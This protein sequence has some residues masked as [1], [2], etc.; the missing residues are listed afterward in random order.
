MTKIPN[1]LQQ[2]LTQ[3]EQLD[4]QK[5]WEQALHNLDPGKRQVLKL[6]LLMC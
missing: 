5:L 3:V 1:E 6:Y 2:L 4:T